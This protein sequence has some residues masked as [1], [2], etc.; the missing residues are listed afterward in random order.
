MVCRPSTLYLEL[1]NLA[2]AQSYFVMGTDT[3]VG[4]TYVARALITHFATAG[5]SVVGMKPVASG[6]ELASQ[7][8]WQGE[9]VNDDVTTLSKASNISASLDLINPYRFS[10]AIAPHI[11]AE[12]SS[13]DIDLAVITKSYHALRAIADV[14]IVEGAGGFFVPINTQQTLADLAVI[15]NIPLVLVV[16]MRLGCINHALL[17]VAAIKSHGLTLAGWV[18]N[19]IDPEMENF[20]ENVASLQQRIAAPCLSIVNWQSELTLESGALLH[21]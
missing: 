9:L 6:C 8:G 2:M 14:V 12:Q 3:N 15:L 5:F 1:N 21:S 19:Q 20:A 10:P 17:T 16:G 13:V 11:A 7:G 4:K 18:A